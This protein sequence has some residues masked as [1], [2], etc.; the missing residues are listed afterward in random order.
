MKTKKKI[1][2]WGT[3]CLALAMILCFSFGVSAATETIYSCGFDSAEEAL[4]WSY[5]DGDKDGH[6]W[7]YYSEVPESKVKTG[8]L[9]DYSFYE[10]QA[11]APKDY[12]YT[13]AFIMPQNGEVYLDYDVFALNPNFTINENYSVYIYSG[14]GG[15][16]ILEENLSKGED[17]TS[18]ATRSL[19]LSD[20][21]VVNLSKYRGK[22]V[23]IGF[24]YQ[25]H[26]QYAI[27]IDN[28]KVYRE[29]KDVNEISVD[30]TKP[31]ISA[32]PATTA[33]VSGGYEGYTVANVSWEPADS[34]FEADKLYSAV[35][36]LEAKDGYAFT[37]DV[38]PYVNHR[39]ATIITK[40]DG[41]MKLSFIFR[42]LVTSP[43]S[44]FFDDVKTTNW[45]Y[46]DV[47]FVYYNRL[48]VGT[49]DNKFSPA[50]PTTRGMVVAV[51]YRLKD[52]PPVSGKC[53]FNDV[54]AGIY[55]EDAITWA[56]EKGIVEGYG[57]HI[58]APDKEI[59][60]QELASIFCHFAKAE[61]F[62]DANDSVMLA[63]F[64]DCGE[65]GSW[66]ESSV[67]WAFGVGL[68]KGSDEKD[69]LYFLPKNP[70]QRCHVAAM[71]ER[72]C[73]AYSY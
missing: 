36:T 31:L 8:A 41:E 33:S 53:P 15:E 43:P 21:D 29:L 71:M 32:V 34:V 64:K 30:V 44:M 23:K 9:I 62:Y 52:E 28:I 27:G 54:K 11:L 67:S 45:F 25:S 35:I 18:P 60:R 5:I 26:N 13:P 7:T 1:P 70:A 66:A 51:L 68:I 14:T 65:I 4:T 3:M 40:S 10:N 72:L 20:S 55:Y 38:T 42:K 69:G 59:S 46:H 6:Y 2:V 56:A 24:V 22:E 37:D 12:A 48:M 73:T 58:F 63:G 16:R 50:L 19:K 57:N 47:E 49:G 17:C 61:G 39:P